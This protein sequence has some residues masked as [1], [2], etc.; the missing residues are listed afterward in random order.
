MDKVR[1]R[2]PGYVLQRRIW[3]KGCIDFVIIRVRFLLLETM[4]LVLM[5]FLKKS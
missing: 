3:G 5:E 1:C 4:V 2:D